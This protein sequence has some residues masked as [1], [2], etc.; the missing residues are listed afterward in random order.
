MKKG[1]III[2][3]A[4]AAAV[5]LKE[6]NKA[7]KNGHVGFYATDVLWNEPP[8]LKAELELI[9]NRKVIATSHIGAQTHEAQLRVAE[10][11][12]RSVKEVLDKDLKL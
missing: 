3:T 2:N 8:K 1:I 5:D 10:A 9:H 7:I 11:I 6:L 12:L 4:R